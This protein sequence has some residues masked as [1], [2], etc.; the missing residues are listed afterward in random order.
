MLAAALVLSGCKKKPAPTMTRL[1]QAPPP[2]AQQPAPVPQ[3]RPPIPEETAEAAETT[4]ETSP[5]TS[6]TR[7]PRRSAARTTPVPA[8]PE[9]TQPAGRT[10]VEEGSAPAE[11]A[12]AISTR[13]SQD[14]ATNTRQHTASLLD[15]TEA[16]LKKL[17]RALNEQEKAMVQQIRTYVTD[18]RAAMTAGDLVRAQTLALKAHLLSQ[19]LVK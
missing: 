13:M 2:V 18:S 17:N 7:S 4:P 12:P 16:N 3:E 8:A 15:Q 14:Q 9:S 6:K 5:A 19:E 11:P 1:P 10:V